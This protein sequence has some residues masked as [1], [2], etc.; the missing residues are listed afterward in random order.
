[1]QSSGGTLRSPWREAGQEGL[2]EEKGAGDR[3]ARRKERQEEWWPRG[4]QEGG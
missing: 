3:R 2:R 1:M 4:Q